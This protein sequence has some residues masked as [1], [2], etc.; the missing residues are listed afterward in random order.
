MGGGWMEARYLITA[1]GGDIGSSVAR[2]LRKELSGK[3]LAGCDLTPYAAGRE[4][5]ETFFLAPPYTEEQRYIDT[6]RKACKSYGITHILPMTEGEILLYD[7]Y[8]EVFYTDG[9][10]IMINSSSI[11]DTA[12]SKYRTAETI[13]NMGLD[14]P[15]TWKPGEHT[16]KIPYPVIVKPDR[17][18]GSRKVRVAG[19]DQ[20]YQ[21][22][23]SEIPDAV[24]QEYIGTPQEEYTMG[25]FSNGAD[26][27]SIT[28]RRVLAGGM[29][30][31]VQFIEDAQT[32]RIAQTA[33]RGLGLKG[34]INIQMRK[35]KGHYCIFEINPR[36]S[37]TVG[38]R[39]L[40]GFKDVLWWLELLD[41]K[42]GKIP[43]LQVRQ[44]VV[45]IRT[46]GEKIFTG[47]V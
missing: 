38:F 41:G 27:K 42:T 35:H 8:R 47:Q 25:V 39:Y 17:G 10:K 20:E 23:I 15:K 33:A 4:D 2:I 21:S 19:N 18:C 5:V 44:S 30:C 12:M 1:V 11:L 14:S 43:D 29:T 32:C 34:C 40:L 24:V 13:A 46:Y 26:T 45:G 3:A 16:Q 37:G 28:F 36:I 22:A 7:Q 6:I 31:R 9:I